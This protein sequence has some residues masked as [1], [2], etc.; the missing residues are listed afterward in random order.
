MTHNCFTDH[1]PNRAADCGSGHIPVRGPDG[2]SGCVAG[3]AFSRVHDGVPVA[4]ARILPA[5][6]FLLFVMLVNSVS[7][8]ADS[9]GAGQQTANPTAES[10]SALEQIANPTAKSRSALVQAAS[11]TAESRSAL[12]QTANPTAESRSALVQ[13]ASPTAES[14]SALEQIANPTAKSRSALVQAASPTAEFRSTSA[15]DPVAEPTGTT[16]EDFYT[17]ALNY[18]PRLRMARGA[19]AHWHG[20]QGPGHRAA[21]TPNHSQ[22]QPFR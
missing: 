14:R 15:A 18:S 10:R 6:C 5:L 21:V 11:P 16:L 3:D 19:V 13:A 1:S 4:V 22:C 20:P 8:A 7:L 12:E 2:T 17:A 9:T